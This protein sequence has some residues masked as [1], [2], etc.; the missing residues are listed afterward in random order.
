MTGSRSFRAVVVSSSRAGCC[1]LRR[2][3]RRR[4]RSHGHVPP[5]TVT[6]AVGSTVSTSVTNGPGSGSDWL[7]L[8]A[9][10]EPEGA[11]MDWRYLN[12]ATVPPSTG[13]TDAT[14]NFTMPTRVS[15][16]DRGAGQNS[17]AE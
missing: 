1:R 13:L 10:D 5:D 17:G 9:S 15:P 16:P 4:S 3:R 8:Y 12:G 7:A 14:V 11:Y 2:L 6:V